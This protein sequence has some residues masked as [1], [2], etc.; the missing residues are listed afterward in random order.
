MQKSIK[1]H[2]HPIYI[3]V[4]KRYLF[5]YNA[6]PV[7]TT[8]LQQI[9]AIL[10]KYWIYVS[11]YLPIMLFPVFLSVPMSVLKPTNRIVDSVDLTFWRAMLISSTI[12]SYLLT[13][14]DGYICSR[15]NDKSFLL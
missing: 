15:H 2:L 5:I 9:P 13:A 4:R 14:S 12:A 11:P 8:K 7:A 6:E 1:K 10:T 3:S